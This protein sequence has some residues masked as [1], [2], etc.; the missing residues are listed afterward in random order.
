MCPNRSD[1]KPVGE[2]TFVDMHV[3]L[4]WAVDHERMRKCF[5]FPMAM[6]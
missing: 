3:A 4:R 5:Q 6:W 2:C 1:G